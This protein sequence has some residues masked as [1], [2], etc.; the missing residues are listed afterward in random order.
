MKT[1]KEWIILASV[2]MTLVVG[3]VAQAAPPW[4]KLIPFRSVEANPNKSYWLTEDHGP[5]MILATSFAGEGAEAQ[6]HELVL[7]LR[8]R[9]KVEAYMHKRQFDYTEPVYGKGLNRFGGPKRMKYRNAVKFEE[10][11]VVVGNYTSSDAPGSQDDLELIKTAKPD[12][13]DITGQNGKKTTQRFVALRELQRLVHADPEKRKLGPMRRA[14]IARNPLLPK[15]FF[16]ADGI[17][18]FVVEMN[19]H[20]KHSLLNNPGRYTVRVASFQ[21]EAGFL[22]EDSENKRDGGGGFLGLPPLKKRSKLEIAA[23]NAHRLTEALRKRGIPAYEFHDRFE[24]VV[25]IGSFESVGTRL[26]DGRI[27]LHPEVY[28]IMQSY[29]AERL[30]LP[31]QGQA[32]QPRKLDGIRFDIQPMPVKVPRRSIGA[33]YASGNHR[34]R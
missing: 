5:W 30:H 22:G 10:I 25:T 12:C 33:D 18:P 21:G 6:A 34:L 8:R 27:D 14:F 26:P 11:A 13:L 19:K 29:G 31:H 1:R 3:T 16:V 15:E 9:Y 24:S 20:V 17:D 7:E 23:D 2:V 4:K 28:K 32:L